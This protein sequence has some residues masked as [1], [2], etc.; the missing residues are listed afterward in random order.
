MSSVFDA[1]LLHTFPSNLNL[2][3]LTVTAGASIVLALQPI[4]RIALT[5]SRHLNNQIS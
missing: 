4:E 1:Y 3:V 5:K 2:A